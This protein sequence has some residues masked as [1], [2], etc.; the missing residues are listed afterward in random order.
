M[1][2]LEQKAAVLEQLLEKEKIFMNPLLTF[3]DVCRW[4]G[5]DEVEMNRYLSDELGYDGEG[6]L[7]AYRKMAVERLRE[8][9]GIAIDN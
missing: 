1:T 7:S 8:E 9:Y 4:L 5:A 6:I 2:N 3:G